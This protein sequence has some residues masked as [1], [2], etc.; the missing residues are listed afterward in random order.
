VSGN[1]I[2]GGSGPAGVGIALV[3]GSPLV[4]GNLIEGGCGDSSTTGV[5]VESSSARLQNNL[6]LGGQCPGNGTPLFCGLHLV[7]SNNSNNLDVHSNDIEPLG[8]SADCQSI[9]VLV[10][11]KSGGSGITAGALRN[12]IVSAGVCDHG[13]A[14]S[15]SPGASLQ[16]LQNNDLY[17]PLGTAATTVVLYRHGNTDATTAAQVNAIT[18]AGGNISIDP[19]YASYPRNLHL[20]AQSPCIDQGTTTGAP[21]D[22]A[23]GNARPAGLGPDIGAYEFT[24]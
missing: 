3:G 1:V 10:E 15:E 4:D 12:N 6:I 13:F 21:M 17:A 5:W 2:Q 8:H 14:I 19:G 23:D 11:P 24:E 16:S 20:T 7:S 22:D 9:G 18:P